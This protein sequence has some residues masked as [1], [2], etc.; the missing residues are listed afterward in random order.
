MRGISVK[1][2]SNGNVVWITA[3]DPTGL[4]NVYNIADYESRGYKPD[5][6]KLPDE[7]EVK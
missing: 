2:D 3:V 1:R 6:K 5:W 4:Y 7:D